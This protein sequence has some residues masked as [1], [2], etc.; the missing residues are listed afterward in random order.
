MFSKIFEKLIFNRLFKFFE[1]N[2]LL[3][4]HQS[5]FRPSDSCIYQLLA[6]TRDIFS[7][8]DCNLTLETRSDGFI[9]H[10]GLLFQLVKNGVSANLFQLIKSFLSR[11][12]QRVLLNGQTSD[13]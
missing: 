6:I 10:D 3:S 13:W 7:N 8:F 11:R 1:D 4:E 5:A 9:W 12:F 2:N